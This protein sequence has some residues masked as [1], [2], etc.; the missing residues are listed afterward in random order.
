MAESLEKQLAKILSSDVKMENG[1]TVKQNLESAIDYLYDCIDKYIQQYYLSYTP[2][3]YKRTYDF[4]DS[5]YAENIAQARIVGNRIELS[6]SF[7]DSMSYHRNIFDDH[8]SYVPALI[9]FGWNAPKL[10]SLISGKKHRFTHYEGYHF[11]E[12]AIRMFNRRNP[13]GIYISPSDVTYIYNGQDQSYQ[14]FEWG[15]LSDL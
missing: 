2:S 15:G 1:K 11:I 7:M 13:Y 5:L 3:V 4:R 8:D 9:N 14:W 6:I 10:E 12:K